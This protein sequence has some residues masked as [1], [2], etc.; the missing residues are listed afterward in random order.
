[1]QS[2]RALCVFTNTHWP[3]TALCPK[4]LVDAGFEVHAYCPPEHLVT[5]SR[6]IKEWFAYPAPIEVTT[7]NRSLAVLVARGRP[8]VV[9]AVDDPALGRPPVGRDGQPLRVAIFPSE[10]RRDP[11]RPHLLGDVHDVPW[12]D[13]HLLAEMTR[14][15]EPPAQRL[16]A[17]DEALFSGTPQAEEPLA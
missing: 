9:L 6:Y 8:D 14:R 5:Y 17:P 1:M 7:F 3:A 15:F 10:W 16:R 2:P 11:S 13:R 12:D 4:A